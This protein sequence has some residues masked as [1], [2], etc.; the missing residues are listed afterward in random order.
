MLKNRLEELQAKLEAFGEAEKVEAV[1][2][3]I[4]R[5]GRKTSRFLSDN[6]APLALIVAG[7][8][9][10]VAKKVSSNGAEISVQEDIEKPE[11][12]MTGLDPAVP[13]PQEARAEDH[14]DR[15]IEEFI[16]P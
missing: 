7:A 12:P 8:G 3:Q 10:M 2:V 16:A 9:W 14:T 5:A 1:Q 4:R 13:S 6:A 11:F 15:P